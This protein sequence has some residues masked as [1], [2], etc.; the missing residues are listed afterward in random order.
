[1]SGTQYSSVHYSCEWCPPQ[2]VSMFRRHL[3]SLL[4][5]LSR[6][7]IR[8]QRGYVTF[9]AIGHVVKKPRG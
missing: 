4:L 3:A 7:V 6:R 5:Y 8:A 9:L 1:M 2:R